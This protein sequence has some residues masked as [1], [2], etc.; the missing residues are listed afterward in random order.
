MKEIIESRESFE[1][2]EP[3]LAMVETAMSLCTVTV[4]I[5]KVSQDPHLVNPTTVSNAN[6]IAVNI[7]FL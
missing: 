4:N 3:I 6:K 2:I 7:I 1:R 5:A